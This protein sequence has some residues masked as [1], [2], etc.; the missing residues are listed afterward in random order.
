[1]NT[2]YFIRDLTSKN[3][4]D[5]YGCNNYLTTIN[6]VRNTVFATRN[7]ALSWLKENLDTIIYDIPGIKYVEI[8]EVIEIQN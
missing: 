4:I 8:Q 6:Q 1:M 7:S 3:Y 2:Q 5:W